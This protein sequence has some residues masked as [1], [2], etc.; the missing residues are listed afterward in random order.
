MHIL[1]S[2]LIIAFGTSH[3]LFGMDIDDTPEPVSRTQQWLN[4][5][6]DFHSYP[7]HFKT[8]FKTLNEDAQG[9]IIAQVPPRQTIDELVSDH[10]ILV[11][12]LTVPHIIASWDIKDDNF[13]YY[14]K[15]ECDTKLDEDEDHFD[16][17][18]LDLAYGQN[19]QI[20]KNETIYAN[21]RP[22]LAICSDSV[23]FERCREGL[24]ML[25]LENPEERTLLACKNTGYANF[26]CH[27]TLP[28]FAIVDTEEIVEI[29]NADEQ[30]MTFRTSFHS[31]PSLHP[32]EHLQWHPTLPVVITTAICI[33]GASYLHYI[34]L[35]E[36]STKA[37]SGD[38]NHFYGA[39]SISYDG[40]TI[41]GSD[42]QKYSKITRGCK[43]CAHTNRE[44]QTF[45]NKNR[46][47]RAVGEQYYLTEDKIENSESTRF[48]L[49]S[50]ET[51]EVVREI[52]S[53]KN[54]NA[55]FS[56]LPQ[57][58]DY[59]YMTITIDKQKPK[60]TISIAV[61][62]SQA[63]IEHY[64]MFQAALSAEEAANTESWDLFKKPAYHNLITATATHYP[65]FKRL[66]EK[67]NIMNA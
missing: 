27:Q 19:T 41:W 23:V 33:S 28:L 49:R 12:E 54:H 20:L 6:F 14:T 22:K 52:T 4:L 13:V 56:R 67:N 26:A 15:K 10:F 25:K 60:S 29:Y 44:N 40:N 47:L 59:R 21:Q 42:G 34:W 45:P 16:M 50:T 17:Y 24:S 48:T 35:H 65:H 66:M 31:S 8:Y 39:P 55:T 38:H 37:T 43:S 30:I 2:F 61:P 36:N 3:A 9:R 5:A 18:H 1:F 51:K 58:H 53:F 64:C 7:A 57:N 63:C 32:Y 11:R 62:A 46:A